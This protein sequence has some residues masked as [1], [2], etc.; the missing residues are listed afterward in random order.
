M[1]NYTCTPDITQLNPQLFQSLACTAMELKA[2]ELNYS[3]Y[4]FT[5]VRLAMLTLANIA[6][7]S[8]QSSNCNANKVTLI[9][10]RYLLED[11]VLK[12]SLHNKTRTTNCATLRL[13][14][15]AA[16]FIWQRQTRKT[17]CLQSSC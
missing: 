5:E 14:N 13:Q 8:M 3:K 2:A 9:S 1:Q 16:Q 11:K 6:K 4:Q 17:I 7:Q 10:L 15:T 12:P